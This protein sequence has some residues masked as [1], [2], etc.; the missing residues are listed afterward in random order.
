MRIFKAILDRLNAKKN[1]TLPSNVLAD[2]FL[3]E[4]DPTSSP[5]PYAVPVSPE[6]R[7]TK[8]VAPKIGSLGVNFF[9]V[10]VNTTINCFILMWLNKESACSPSTNYQSLFRNAAGG[11]LLSPGVMIGKAIGKENLSEAREIITVSYVLT[12]LLTFF[13]SIAYGASYFL[14]PKLFPKET[15]NTAAMYLLFSGIGTLPSLLLVTDNQ[16]GYQAGDW[17]SSLLSNIVY[18]GSAPTLGYY[19]AIPMGMGV[20]GL[21]LGNAI[22]PWIAWIGMAA[23]LRREK[24]SH[25]RPESLSKKI[26]KKHLGPL[27]LLGAQMALQKLTEWGN[28]MIIT[29]IIGRMGNVDYLT[30][31]IPSTQLMTVLNQVA[32]GSGQGGNMIL[33]IA[34]ARLKKLIY[35]FH[36]CDS[37]DEKLLIQNDI[38]T[39]QQDIIKTSVISFT[40]GICINTL[41]AIALYIARREISGFFMP[42]DASPETHRLAE[43]LLWI[44]GIGLVTDAGR[45]ISACL[46]N[47]YDKILFPNIVS[48][49]LMTLIGISAN[50]GYVAIR[51]SDDENNIISLFAIR[52]AM[53]FL[54]AAINCRVLYQCIT[55]DQ[56]KIN[57]FKMFYNKPEENISSRSLA[58]ITTVT[59]P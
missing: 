15:A 2:P 54:A 24:F 27:S 36:G 30:A 59:H 49:V 9:L 51:N 53:I 45:I 32:Q 43:T 44:N 22:A 48:L 40:I 20:M 46:L 7:A 8:S 56:K 3:T 11:V 58:E 23:W 41:C 33:A 6:S 38:D 14:F 12:I 55:K 31:I 13:S 17:K 19:L 16:I 29:F 18:R 52:T 50:Y 34:H 39:I 47:T 28:L 25:L 37:P 26:I 21:G 4:S 35:D 10:S 5:H 42:H 1:P 57:K